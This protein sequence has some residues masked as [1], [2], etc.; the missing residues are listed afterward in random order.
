MS[1]KAIARFKQLCIE[2]GVGPKGSIGLLAWS[3]MEDPTPDTWATKIVTI[4]QK[5]GVEFGKETDY[6]KLKTQ[7]ADT[8]ATTEK[9]C[10][11]P[12]TLSSVTDG[13]DHYPINTAEQARSALDRAAQQDKAPSWF[14]GSLEDLRKVIVCAV[15]E[16]FPKTSVRM[17][18]WK[19]YSHI[20]T[21]DELREILNAK[22]TELY[23]DETDEDSLYTYW[24]VDILL[25]ERAVIARNPDGEY[26]EI[27]YDLT[28]DGDIELLDPIPVRKQW[29]AQ[30]AEEIKTVDLLDVEL[31]AAGTT[32]TPE[33]TEADITAMAEAS[34]ELKSELPA[35]IFTGHTREHGWPAFGWVE[36]VRAKGTKLVGD[37]MGVPETIATWIKSRGFRRVSAEIW[38]NYT[39]ENK[40]TYPHVL[41][42]LALLGQDIPRCRILKDLPIPAYGQKTSLDVYT[43]GAGEVSLVSNGQ[44]GITNGG[45]L[46][47]LKNKDGHIILEPVRYAELV[48]TE[49]QV[50]T[51]KDQATQIEE[52]STEIEGLKKKIVDLEKA[53]AA[54]AKEFSDYR[55]G[56]KVAKIDYAI[57]G[58]KKT[59]RLAPAGEAKVRSF[60]VS[61]SDAKTLKYG[62]GEDAVETSQLDSYLADL[63]AVEEG[64]AIKFG[65][66]SQKLGDPDY[67]GGGDPEEKLNAAVKAY[68]AKEKCTYSV[69]LQAVK[70]SNPELC[71]HYSE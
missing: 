68:V 55:E 69:A 63:G 64:S 10:I 29:I 25:D 2:D 50:T 1:A 58:L 17:E 35:P 15:K 12:N 13:K 40:K 62:E 42:G 30:Y 61:L 3:E 67:Q 34:Q 70:R 59:G 57:K 5:A 56:V 23:K 11:F 49:K 7:P 6:A 66:L 53:G 32:E 21:Y 8:Y 45:E 41:C 38:P 51:L 9:D 20:G 26:V 33:F 54:K 27:P 48:E 16:K 60:A 46:N 47:M 4:L 14:S 22:L 19:K 18:T 36:N 65:I 37:L 24:L 44:P 43:F 39:S 31:F 52:F 71:K 28:V